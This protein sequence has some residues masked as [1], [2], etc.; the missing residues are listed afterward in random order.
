MSRFS[1][2]L[3]AVAALG[4]AGI[5][6]AAE[7]ASEV[8][9]RA[10]IAR[11]AD[12]T[13]PAAGLA[14]SAEEAPPAPGRSPKGPPVS[15]FR[16]WQDGRVIFEGKGYAALPSSQIVAELKASD[17]GAGRLQVLDLYQG[18]CVLELPK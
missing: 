15:L 10:K 7:D 18:V 4:C 14:R 17:G 11:A 8:N 2:T 12:E 6:L 5:A 3:I 16:C 13:G 9:V 1:K